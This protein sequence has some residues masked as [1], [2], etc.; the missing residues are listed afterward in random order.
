[1]ADRFHVTLGGQGHMVAP[2]SYRRQQSGAQPEGAGP[3]RLAQRDCGGGGL[4]GPQLERD[5]FWTSV[6]LRPVGLGQGVG[7][8]PKER[9]PLPV[10]GLDQNAPRHAVLAGG[11]P[12][13][14]A[15]QA[16]WQVDRTLGVNP[17]NLGGCTQLGGSLGATASGLAVRD[18]RELFVARGGGDLWRWTI[19][20]AGFTAYALPFKGVAVYANSVWGLGS[21]TEPTRLLRVTDLAAAAV[22]PAGW[23]LD[24]ALRGAALARDALYVATAGA[25]WRVRGTQNSAGAFTF[26]VQPVLFAGGAG[27]GDAFGALVEFGGDLFTWYGG[28]VMRYHATGTGA[29]DLAPTGLTAGYCRG[30]AVAGGYLVAAVVDTPQYGGGQLWAYDGHGWWCLARN[31][32][33]GSPDYWAPMPTASYVQDAD[34]IAFS[35]GQNTLH[36]FQLRSYSAQPGLAPGGELITSLWHGRDPDQEK[37]WLRVGAEFVTPGRA[38]SPGL[39]SFSPCTVALAYTLDG[40]NFSAAGSATID[41]AGARTIAFDLPPGTTGKLL[42]LKYSLSGVTEGAPTL[43]ALWAEYRPAEPLA[44]RRAWAFEVLAGDGM[45]ARDGSRDA[46]SGRQIAAALWAAWQA[47]AALAF[48]DLDYDLDPTPRTVRIANLDERIAAPADA[49]RWGESR[50]RVELVEV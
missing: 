38:S 8:G 20:G 3:Q 22:D 46:R 2:G 14:A 29:A 31:T 42:A 44:C 49:G 26:D 12:Y 7:P 1:M 35:K 10:A 13:F 15:G 32:G 30:L 40:S 39:P 41:T 17:E 6:G 4:R 28:Q 25:L 50:L 37:V 11:R 18:D 9:A 33:G 16:L 36:G 24:S 45:V 21:A 27:F 23:Y 19:G 48:R 43:T 5:R 47:G 34:L